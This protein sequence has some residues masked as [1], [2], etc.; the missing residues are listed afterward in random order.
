M[1]IFTLTTKRAQTTT[2]YLQLREN[3]A[4]HHSPIAVP[5]IIP[6]QLSIEYRDSHITIYTYPPQHILW[7]F[8]WASIIA[9][10]DGQKRTTHTSIWRFPCHRC[11]CVRK[12]MSLSYPTRDKTRSL[13]YIVRGYSEHIIL[14]F[15]C[16]LNKKHT[17]DTITN[18]T[19]Y[20]IWVG[21][22]IGRA[23]TRP[24]RADASKCTSQ[25]YMRLGRP[26]NC[27]PAR[28][29]TWC[30]RPRFIV[31]DFQF[32]SVIVRVIYTL[33]WCQS[34]VV[35]VGRP[36]PRWV[37]PGEQRR[38]FAVVRT[39]RGRRARLH[40]VCSQR[41]QRPESR[42]SFDYQWCF[43][44]VG[45]NWLR[46]KHIYICIHFVQNWFWYGAKRYINCTLWG[47]VLKLYKSDIN[48]GSYICYLC[49]IE[50]KK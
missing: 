3:P 38:G 33:D 1:S 5:A 31:Y 34:D 10:W 13:L 28:R 20:I 11:R 25:A 14:V 7:F 18:A 22:G 26:E 37:R 47:C 48:T 44:K 16:C 39:A 30:E 42:A 2:F 41:R 35:V 40:Q 8:Q 9:T 32:N 12:N 45:R 43:D 46:H 6:L 50:Q 29:R 4:S 15:V 49:E 19:T 36:P 21:H 27:W 23:T 17:T 24:T